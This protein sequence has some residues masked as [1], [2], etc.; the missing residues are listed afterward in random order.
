M[1]VSAV[2]VPDAASDPA[3]PDHD[4]WVKETTLAMEVRH[5]QFV[6]GTLRDAEAENARLLI[7]MEA[8]ARESGTPVVKPRKSRQERALDRAVTVKA[9][10][11][12]PELTLQKK[13]PC[14]RCGVCRACMRERRIVAIAAKAKNERD[15]WA[16]QTGWKIAMMLWS[17]QAGT[18]EFKGKS[19][20]DVNR[21]V[22]AVA[23]KV[24]DESVSHGFGKWI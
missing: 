11:P 6:G 4:R 14:G 3:H 17:A 7:R 15:G 22:T 10:L 9:A 13:S 2:H 20:E 24:C 19:A 16:I 21:I 1:K 5:A 23:E 8:L 18:G 12:R